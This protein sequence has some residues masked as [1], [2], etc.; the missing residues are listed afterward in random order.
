MRI[1]LKIIGITLVV[2]GVLFYIVTVD[3]VTDAD[4]IEISL[5][6]I[7]EPVYDY[8]LFFIA[9]TLSVF[10]L[11]G[12]LFITYFLVCYEDDIVRRIVSCAIVFVPLFCMLIYYNYVAISSLPERTEKYIEQI[13]S[14]K[15]NDEEASITDIDN[16]ICFEFCAENEIIAES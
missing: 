14:N 2:I 7:G 8:F 15:D 9:N 4:C 11:C 16:T 1:L 13:E 10:V 5:N 6:E 12:A 3:S